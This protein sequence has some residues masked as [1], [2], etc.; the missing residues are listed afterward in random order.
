M[1]KPKISQI[2]NRGQIVIPKEIRQ[3]LN[4]SAGT[5]FYIYDL[6]N[7]GIL[8]KKIPEVSVNIEQAQREIKR[9]FKK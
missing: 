1:N 6:S 8:L 3:K 4:I 9:R 7:D 5:G 2:D